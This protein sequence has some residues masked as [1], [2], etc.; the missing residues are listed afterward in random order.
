MYTARIHLK[1]QTDKTLVMYT[2]EELPPKE[3][4]KRVDEPSLSNYRKRAGVLVFTFVAYAWAVRLETFELIPAPLG[5]M[6]KLRLGA[7]SPGG[8]GDIPCS[9]PVPRL[10]P[11]PGLPVVRK[12]GGVRRRGRRVDE[13]AA[14]HGSS[15]GGAAPARAPTPRP[16]PP[17][18]APARLIRRAVCLQTRAP[19]RCAPP[20][21]CA[22]GGSWAGPRLR[23]RGLP[24]RVAAGGRSLAALLP[25]PRL[26][27]AQG[28][29]PEAPTP[30]AGGRA[31]R[32]PGLVCASGRWAGAPP[33]RAPRAG[34]ARGRVD[35][36]GG[37]RAGAR[38]AGRGAGGPGHVVRAPRAPLG[39]PGAV[40]AA[41]YD[42][43]QAPRRSA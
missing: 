15:P 26:P 27:G 9:P 14:E 41:D 25:F 4:S 28:D 1:L 13:G 38:G 10:G 33:P 6:G 18:R 31:A 29:S 30:R 7:R 23:L 17:A 3:E 34:P 20:W 22:A 11:R 8:N 42:S 43:R 32:G 19:G 40:P 39:R 35:G 16:C 12:A 2:P 24:G 37:R 21:P 36:A 5:Q